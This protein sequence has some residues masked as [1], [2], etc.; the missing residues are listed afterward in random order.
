MTAKQVRDSEITIALEG[1]ID[2]LTYRPWVFWFV[3]ILTD[4]TVPR[5]WVSRSDGNVSVL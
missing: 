2:L 1:P 5:A 3:V 4:Q